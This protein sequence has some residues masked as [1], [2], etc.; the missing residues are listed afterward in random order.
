MTHFFLG[1]INLYK[2]IGFVSGLFLFAVCMLEAEM[3]VETG[4]GLR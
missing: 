3:K 4:T 2:L 1:Q